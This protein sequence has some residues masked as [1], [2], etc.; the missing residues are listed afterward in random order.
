VSDAAAVHRI[1]TRPTR[2]R[3]Q[4]P[5][6]VAMETRVRSFTR[7]RRVALRPSLFLLWAVLS[8]VGGQPGVPENLKI[9]QDPGWDHVVEL[10]WAHRD[11]VMLWKVQRLCADGSGAPAGGSGG[12][13]SEADVI[14]VAEAELVD[15]VRLNG[16][17]CAY[18]VQACDVDGCGNFTA[19]L[20]GTVGAPPGAPG[21]R[22][23]CAVGRVRADG[24][25]PTS[26]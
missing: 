4:S 2:I 8:L 5:K 23:R 24:A 15:Y 3:T 18:R 26:P 20:N 10:T 6:K 16:G 14:S 12:P 7:D 11:D 19:L 22:E 1:D 21:G 17:T 9:R 13:G 25:L